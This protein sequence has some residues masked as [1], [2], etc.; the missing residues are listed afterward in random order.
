V[1]VLCGITIGIISSMPWKMKTA[2]SGKHF[3]SRCFPFAATATASAAATTTSGIC[4]SNSNLQLATT[5][6]YAVIIARSI[7]RLPAIQ[8]GGKTFFKHMYL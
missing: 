4:G 6:S 5:C 7:C 1:C 2:N 3:P 8:V